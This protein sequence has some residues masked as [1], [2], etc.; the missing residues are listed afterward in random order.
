MSS[1]VMGLTHSPGSAS[2]GMAAVSLAL[3]TDAAAV[4]GR[5]AEAKRASEQWAAWRAARSVAELRVN[6]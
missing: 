3:A 2:V 4:V 1:L 6:E 5:R